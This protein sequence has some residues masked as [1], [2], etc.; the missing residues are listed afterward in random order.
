MKPDARP[1]QNAADPNGFCSAADCRLTVYQTV[2]AATQFWLVISLLKQKTQRNSQSVR[3]KGNKFTVS[4]LLGVE[5][6]SDEA[7]MFEDGSVAI[8][9]YDAVSRIH[10]SR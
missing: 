10:D 3:I 7:R 5:P 9:R 8:F 4:A 2:S 1:V 6:K